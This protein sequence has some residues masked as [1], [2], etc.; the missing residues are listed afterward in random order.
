[1][2]EASVNAKCEVRRPNVCAYVRRYEVR[3]IGFNVNSCSLLAA[4]GGGPGRA[5]NSSEAARAHPHAAGHTTLDAFHIRAQPLES[6]K[7]PLTAGG[8]RGLDMAHARIELVEL[9]HLAH[10]V[11]RQR[12]RQVR[13]VGEDE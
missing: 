1:M 12:V 5:V 9:Q 11:R 8:A 7:E 2:C 13:L 10:L 6:L 3:V 4:R